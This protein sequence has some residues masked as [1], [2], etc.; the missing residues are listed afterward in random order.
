[1]KNILEEFRKRNRKETDTVEHLFDLLKLNTVV[2]E[3]LI[4]RLS[5]DE[6]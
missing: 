5:P 2:S 6:E 1:M 3:Y 4:S